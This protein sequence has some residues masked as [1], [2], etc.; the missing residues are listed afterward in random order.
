MIEDDARLIFLAALERAPDQWPA[1]LDEAC[2][3]NAELRA[4]VEQLLHS[5]YDRFA[6]DATV[7]TF[8]PLLAERAPRQELKTIAASSA[9]HMVGVA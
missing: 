9:G 1:F 5:N 3:D 7:F 4:R 8:L 2:A 6:T